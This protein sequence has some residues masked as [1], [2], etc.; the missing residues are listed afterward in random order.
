MGGRQEMRHMWP[1]DCVN[2]DEKGTGVRMK[3]GS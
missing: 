2:S 3:T 1:K